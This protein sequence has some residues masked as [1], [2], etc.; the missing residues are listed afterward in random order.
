[1]KKLLLTLTLLT[2]F[3]GNAQTLDE[4]RE[5]ARSHY[6]EIARFGLID[7]TEQF[8]LSNAAKAWLPQGAVSARLTWQNSVMELPEQFK[9]IMQMQGVD[10][11]GLKLLQYKIGVDLNQNIWDGG[12]TAASR[13]KIKADA[14]VER[15][16][17]EVDLYEVDSRVQDVYFGLL[18]IDERIAAAQ[19][20]ATL[21]DSTLR[22]VDALVANGVAMRSD[23]QQIAARRLTIEQ[24]I[25]KLNGQR[26]AYEAVLSVFI[27]KPLGEI[28]RPAA[29]T[30]VAERP[31]ERLFDSRLNALAAAR[32]QINASVMPRVSAFVNAYLGYPGLNYFESMGSTKM[33]P[34]IIAG[35][36]L[37]WNFGAL[38][39]LK[40]SL[41][42]IKTQAETIQNAREIFNFNRKT[43]TASQTEQI[44]SLRRVIMHDDE[45][46]AL[47][48]EVLDAARAQLKNGV[49]DTTA[50]LSKFTDAELAR[51]DRETHTLELLQAQYK[52]Y[53]TENQ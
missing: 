18:L 37:Q 35:I 40:N 28:S 14:E 17:T 5:L 16:Q 31:T 32:K 43:A 6:P 3:T 7:Q 21:L 1:M 9:N 52:L 8:S 25:E 27:G 24:Q 26:K 34:N 45:I 20:T 30:P 2:S 23:R 51:T 4:C 50:L 47:Q 19:L 38:Y 48:L 15:R 41:N 39:T 12:Q 44:E 33:T 13:S 29:Y 49:L 53:Q 11:P 36:N 22:Q 10:Y 42:S 46:L